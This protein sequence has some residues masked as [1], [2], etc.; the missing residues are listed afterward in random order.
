MYKRSGA[1]VTE[2]SASHA[3]EISQPEA[4]ARVIEDAA[5]HAN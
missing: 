1:K 3:V 5:L 4:V 2:I